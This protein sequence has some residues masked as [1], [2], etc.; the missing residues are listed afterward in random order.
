M[1]AMDIDG[2]LLD[3]GDGLYPPRLNQA[4]VN[5]LVNLRVREVSLV[6]RLA[7]RTGWNKTRRWALVPIG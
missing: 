1:I 4:L 6:T 7:F 2:T 5:S 3:Y